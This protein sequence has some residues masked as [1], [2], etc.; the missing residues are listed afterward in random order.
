MGAKHF[1]ATNYVFLKNTHTSN[2]ELAHI[3]EQ[4][5]GWS[6]AYKYL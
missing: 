4:S 6:Q 3:L 1:L 5:I 2:S